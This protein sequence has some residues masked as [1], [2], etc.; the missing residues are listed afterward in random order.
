[1][2]LQQITLNCL[3]EEKKKQSESQDCDKKIAETS[4]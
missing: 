4:D 2:N 3:K 1:M